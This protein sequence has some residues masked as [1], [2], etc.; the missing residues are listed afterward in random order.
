MKVKL[1]HTSSKCYP[2]YPFGD[3]ACSP[4]PAE[5]LGSTVGMPCCL[6]TQPPQ[7]GN[8]QPEPHLDRLKRDKWLPQEWPLL[9]AGTITRTTPSLTGVF[10]HC[11][12][13]F[14]KTTLFIF[15]I[16]SWEWKNRKEL[17]S[18]WK[19]F[20]LF[21][22]LTEIIQQNLGQCFFY[23]FD[24]IKKRTAI[25]NEILEWLRRCLT[26]GGLITG[27]RLTGFPMLTRPCCL[28]KQVSS[29]RQ[30]GWLEASTYPSP[31]PWG[32]YQI[33]LFWPTPPQK[34]LPCSPNSNPFSPYQLRCTA[35]SLE[36]KALWYLCPPSPPCTASLNESP[37]SF[38]T[39]TSKPPPL[40]HCSSIIP[41]LTPPCPVP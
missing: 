31:N 8:H 37:V 16:A 39:S 23:D 1:A 38:A 18:Q 13:L 5:I 11:V 9:G 6:L 29:A 26:S 4:F 40:R 12:L 36:C 19:R 14:K 35:L 17:I 30:L 34:Q 28:W 24:W 10:Q 21:D 33:N 20:C 3:S 25:A 15:G 32:C 22:L 41:S 27:L 7:Q 2:G